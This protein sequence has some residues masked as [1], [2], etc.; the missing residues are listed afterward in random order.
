MLRKR[1]TGVRK[2]PLKGWGSLGRMGLSCKTCSCTAF[3][4]SKDLYSS[5]CARCGHGF[6]KH[7]L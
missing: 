4:R 6:S 7:L 2:F 3:K 5:K 1:V